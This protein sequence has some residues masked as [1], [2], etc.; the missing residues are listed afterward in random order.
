MPSL[1]KTALFSRP[2]PLSDD[3]PDP[4]GPRGEY[5]PWEIIY[6]T[7]KSPLMH[8]VGASSSDLRTGVGWNWDELIR[9]YVFS[10]LHAFQG[11]TV[12]NVVA[13]MGKCDTYI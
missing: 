13:S 9:N 10:T 11:R 6:L 12:D 1:H 5:V 7:E 3:Q 8:R 2:L 4:Y